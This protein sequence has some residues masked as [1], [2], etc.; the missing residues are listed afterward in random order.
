[1]QWLWDPSVLCQQGKKQCATYKSTLFH[2]PNHLLFQSGFLHFISKNFSLHR[3][4]TVKDNLGQ[5]THLLLLFICLSEF[6]SHSLLG[7]M[8]PMPRVLF[9]MARDGLL[10]RPLSKMSDRQSPVIA[11]LAS[12]VVAGKISLQSSIFFLNKIISSLF[13]LL[14]KSLPVL[15]LGVHPHAHC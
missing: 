3:G 8:F 4:H 11:T 6:L 1:M 2:Q 13:V 14:Y 10:F 5:T 9:A 7:S 12:G 15:T